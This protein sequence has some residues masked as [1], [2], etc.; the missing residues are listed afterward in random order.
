[1]T[2]AVFLVHTLTFCAIL[3]LS[4][5]YYVWNRKKARQR[6]NANRQKR[7]YLTASISHRL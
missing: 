7:N 3:Q 4:C 1:M 6:A 5:E 2:Q